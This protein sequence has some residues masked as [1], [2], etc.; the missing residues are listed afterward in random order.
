M[1]NAG[2]MLAFRVGALDA[3][4]IATQ[5]QGVTPVDLVSLPNHHA[6]AQVMV[7]GEKGKVFSVVTQQY[8]K[9]PLNLR[10][11]SDQALGGK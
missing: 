4:T 2:S 10:L 3:P 6:Y 1:G 8:R 7:G 9:V 11:C 5:M